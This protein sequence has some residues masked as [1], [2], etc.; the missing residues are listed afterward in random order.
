MSCSIPKDDSD[1]KEL[2]LTVQ[3]H[4]CTFTCFKKS[5]F[6]NKTKSSGYRFGFPKK[7]FNTTKIL[8]EEEILK[9]KGRFVEMK[10]KKAESRINYYN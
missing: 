4:K 1:L 2:V 6:S 7:N 3:T 5:N 9:T 8:N 10:R